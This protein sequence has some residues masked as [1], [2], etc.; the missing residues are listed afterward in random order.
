MFKVNLRDLKYIFH[1]IHIFLSMVRTKYIKLTH[2]WE[3]FISEINHSI[4]IKFI[5]RDN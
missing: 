2:N 5:I 4:S 3:I 1:V